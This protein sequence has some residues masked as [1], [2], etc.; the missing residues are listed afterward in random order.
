MSDDRVKVNGGLFQNKKKEPGT[1]Q[2]DYT[3]VINVTEEF[4]LALYKRSK[5]G[6][7]GEVKLQLSGWKKKP[8]DERKDAYISLNVD[9]GMTENEKKGKSHDFDDEIPF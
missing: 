2:P 8:K 4:A 7:A 9:F 3:G 6:K 5:S 1:K